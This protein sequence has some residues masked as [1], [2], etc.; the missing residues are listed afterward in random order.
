MARNIN[1]RDRRKVSPSK[2]VSLVKEVYDSLLREIISGAVAPGSYL[3]EA[4]LVEQFNAS[5][6]PIREALIHLHKE[7]LLQK[8]PYKGYFVTSMS[9]DSVR[10]LFELRLLLEPAAARL[11]A[12]NPDARKIME[13]LQ[14]A[15]TQM[16]RADAHVRS[17]ED[18]LNLNKIDTTFHKSIAEASGNKKL[19]NII[20]E[21][22]NQ[23]ERF[24][25]TCFQKRPLFSDTLSEHTNLLEAILC[26]DPTQ[27]EQ[28]MLVHIHNSIERAKEWSLGMLGH[29]GA[30]IGHPPRV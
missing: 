15:H 25:R 19:A 27:A 2:R 21:I 1:H 7:G 6:T 12:R 20:G 16:Q 11:A 29:P 28:L 9:L 10:E 23:F 4:N 13:R 8:G 3:S 30:E 17:F 24:H 22:M 5:R 14:Q 18:S 26:G